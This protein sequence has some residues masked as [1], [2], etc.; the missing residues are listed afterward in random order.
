MNMGGLAMLKL[1][2]ALLAATLVLPI[3]CAAAMPE[4]A[5]NVITTNQF[6]CFIN[7]LRELISSAGK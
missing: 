1:R 3:S 5:T 7:C 2:Y 6:A 4:S